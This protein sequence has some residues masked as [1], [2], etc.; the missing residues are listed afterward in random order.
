[1]SHQWPG[2]QLMCDGQHKNIRQSLVF[3]GLLSSITW[4][5]PGKLSFPLNKENVLFLEQDEQQRESRQNLLETEHCGEQTQLCDMQGQVEPTT[6]VA[7]S[8]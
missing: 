1:M 5:V 3:E 7:W 4:L 6:K 2:G 8:R